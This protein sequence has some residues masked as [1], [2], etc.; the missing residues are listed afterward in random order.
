[1]HAE[2]TLRAPFICRSNSDRPFPAACGV[3]GRDRSDQFTSAIH[4]LRQK[5]EIEIRQTNPIDL[6]IG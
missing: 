4:D 2:P 6:V 1:M 3:V 5:A